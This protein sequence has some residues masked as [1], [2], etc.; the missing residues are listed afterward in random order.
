[1]HM[2]RREK[3]GYKL[4]IEVDVRAITDITMMSYQGLHFRDEMAEK[5]KPK[6]HKCIISPLLFYCLWEIVQSQTPAKRAPLE[7][8]CW[9]LCSWSD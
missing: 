7:F 1:M 5:I 9:V 6:V 8:C 3:N 4:M 2:F